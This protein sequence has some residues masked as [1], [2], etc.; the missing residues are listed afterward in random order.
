MTEENKD[1][2]KIWFSRN[3]R[4]IFAL[5]LLIFVLMLTQCEQMPI[6][7]NFIG[8]CSGYKTEC[9]QTKI[10][11]SGNTL[12]QEQQNNSKTTLSAG[13]VTIIIWVNGLQLASWTAVI[14]FLIWGIVKLIRD[15]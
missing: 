14:G 3:L 2:W 7:K 4:F 13:E 10:L 8:F 5:I 9:V 1:N 12:D 6:K 11:D 15:E